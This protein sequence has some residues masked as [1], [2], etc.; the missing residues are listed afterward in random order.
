MTG[1]ERKRLMICY[2]WFYPAYKAGGPIQS[3]TNLVIAL[4]YEF[5][6]YIFCSSSDL[7]DDNPVSDL[8]NQWIKLVLPGAEIPVQVWYAGP[9]LPTGS[10]VRAVIKDI[11]PHVVYLNGI[12]SYHYFLLPLRAARRAK[13]VVCPRGMLQRGALSGKWFKKMVYLRMLRLTGLTKHVLWHA[14]GEEE[15]NDV[16]KIFGK[17][18]KAAIASNIPRKPLDMITVPPKEEGKLRLIY[19]SLIAEKKNLLG[20][21]NAIAGCEENI[22]LDIYGPVK[23][24][25]Y[26]QRCRKAMQMTKGRVNYNGD[27]K[28]ADVQSVFSK[29]DASILL[30]RGEN[31]GHAIY[32]SLSSGRPVVNSRYTPWNELEQQYAG[33]NVDIDSMEAIKKTLLDICNMKADFFYGYCQGAYRLAVKYYSESNHIDNYKIIF[34]TKA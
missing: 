4:Q 18:V 34:G 2:D 30:T 27:V 22:S 14:T 3:L 5:E 7:N 28:P 1:R 16:R 23:D 17:K 12:F 32:E 10:V 20:V 24:K 25:E 15:M 29:Y 21:I 11:D 31:F 6:I 19:L 9:A 26:W 8:T 13:V 33:W